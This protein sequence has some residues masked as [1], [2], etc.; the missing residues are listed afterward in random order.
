MLIQSSDCSGEM[1]N[2][3]NLD[4][5]INRDGILNIYFN[6][7]LLNFQKSLSKSLLDWL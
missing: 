3:T 6:T 5:E 2:W 1:L 7:F 4:V